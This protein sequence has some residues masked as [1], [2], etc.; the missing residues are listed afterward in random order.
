MLERFAAAILVLLLSLSFALADDL[1]GSVVTPVGP[2]P[3]RASPPGSFFQGKGIE[4]A[5]VN[6][7]EKL[8]VIGQTSV[9]TLAGSEDWIQVQSTSD[10]SLVGWV[11]SGPTGSASPNVV[12]Q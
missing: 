4:I 11:F 8:R 1:T 6:P 10:P 5:I 12:R 3:L 9:R 2:L 7:G